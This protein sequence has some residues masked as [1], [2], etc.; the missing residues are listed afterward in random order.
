[1]DYQVDKLGAINNTAP[2]QYFDVTFGKLRDFT[3]SFDCQEMSNLTQ[4]PKKH[5]AILLF[6]LDQKNIEKMGSPVTAE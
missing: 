1:M 5:M 3:W 2:R 6:R 4:I